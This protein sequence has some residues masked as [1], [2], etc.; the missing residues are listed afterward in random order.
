[1][2]NANDSSKLAC[3]NIPILRSTALSFV[4]AKRLA[5]SNRFGEHTPRL[6]SRGSTSK[7]LRIIYGHLIDSGQRIDQNTVC[8]IVS[9]VSQKTYYLYSRENQQRLMHCTNLVCV[10]GYSMFI[11]DQNHVH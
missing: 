6:I 4:K 10:F 2:R 11:W 5:F 7:T 8:D 3:G 9:R 1:M